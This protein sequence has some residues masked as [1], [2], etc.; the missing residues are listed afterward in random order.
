MGFAWKVKQARAHREALA[1]SNVATGTA[2][3]GRAGTG[4][5]LKAGYAPAG[6]PLHGDYKPQDEGCPIEKT[7]ARGEAAA[8]WAASEKVRNLEVREKRAS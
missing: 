2:K 3:S 4:K 7:I 1:L 5:L 8:A 6:N